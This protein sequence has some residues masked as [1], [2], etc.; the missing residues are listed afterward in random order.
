MDSAGPR[1]VGMLDDD[2]PSM[3]ISFLGT[4]LKTIWADVPW[5]PWAQAHIFHI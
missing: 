1:T 5:E 3:K 2:I 4:A